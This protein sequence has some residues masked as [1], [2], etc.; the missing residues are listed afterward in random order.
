MGGGREHTVKLLGSASYIST[1]INFR[2]WAFVQGQNWT[3][4]KKIK[5]V[6]VL[7]KRL[8]RVG[9]GS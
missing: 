1:L 5:T 9:S 3:F 8:L 7:V 4:L 6:V 2:L